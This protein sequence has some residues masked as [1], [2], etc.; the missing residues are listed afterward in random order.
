[1]PFAYIF[2]FYYL[3]FRN[4]ALPRLQY[5]KIKKN[6]FGYGKNPLDIFE[7]VLYHTYVLP[8]E[9]DMYLHK[10][11]LTYVV[12]LDIARTELVTKIVQTLFYRNYDNDVK[13][14]QSSRKMKK[15]PYIPVAATETYYKKELTVF[16]PFEMRY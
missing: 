12:D 5:L 9:I 8:L 7:P 14:F 3:V 6:T 13:L 11:N 4:L 10:L 15:I 1:M 2:R 16:L